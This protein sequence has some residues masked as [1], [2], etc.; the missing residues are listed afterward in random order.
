MP[1]LGVFLPVGFCEPCLLWVGQEN[2]WKGREIPGN[3]ARHTTPPGMLSTVETRQIGEPL[4][5]ENQAIWAE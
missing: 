4:L 1:K 3:I 5:P 2:N